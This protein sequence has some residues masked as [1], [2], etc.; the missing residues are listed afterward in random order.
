MPSGFLPYARLLR[1]PNVMTAF[2]DILMAACASGA[3]SGL[4]VWL[5]LAS[6]SLY[7][8]GMVFNDLFDR[9]EDAKTQA[10][11]PL[12]SGQVPVRR[13]WLIAHGLMLL[14]LAAAFMVTR[15]TNS[16]SRWPDALTVA[17]LLAAAILLYDAWLK[18]TPLG[19]VGMGLCRGLN[20]WLGLSAGAIDDYA[21]L[22]LSF[23][24]GVYIIGVTLFAKTE[25]AT[26]QR[27]VLIAAT[28]IMAIAWVMALTVPLMAPA[29]PWIY[30]YLLIGFGFYVGVPIGR[31]IHQPKPV[32]VQRAVKRCIFGLVILDAT[33]A[34]AY[35]GWPGLL[36]IALLVPAVI[37]GRWVYST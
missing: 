20:V 24:I 17:V 27:R 25:E 4:T 22:E 13:A 19:P 5:L 10:F 21:G 29:A 26:S 23:I 8:A 1:L 15:S 14:G 30:P 12:P 3:A 6:G 18:R 2:A 35:V 28:V 16:F 36:I 32:H 31:A 11:R 34:T 37:L 33:L 7:L 9:H